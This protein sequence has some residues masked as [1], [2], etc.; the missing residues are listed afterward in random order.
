M[1]TCAELFKKFT[2]TATFTTIVDCDVTFG[3]SRSGSGTLAFF[4]HHAATDPSNKHSAGASSKG[5]R[6]TISLSTGVETFDITISL[7][8]SQVFVEMKH[9]RTTAS[10]VPHCRIPP[11]AMP[12]SLA[13]TL[14]GN[15]ADL[16]D[17]SREVD[18]GISLGNRRD[19]HIPK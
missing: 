7:I 5:Y 13:M 1:P 19:R 3:G 15:G 14:E 9:D 16:F 10:F 17:G 12:S 8:G 4:Q 11:S 2:D 6:G 18:Y